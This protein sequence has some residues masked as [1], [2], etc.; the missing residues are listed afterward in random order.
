MSKAPSLRLLLGELLEVPKLL[1]SLFQPLVPLEHGQQR[2]VLV[3]PGYLANDLSTSRLRRSLKASG[4]CADGW[5]LG[6]NWGARAD[7]LDRLA[8]RLEQLSAAHQGRQV[9]L[10]GWSLGGIY[11]RE[12]AKLRPGLVD[13]VITLGTPFSGELRAN[14]AWWLY[15][16]L[17]DHGVDNPPVKIA[18]AV[19]PPMLTIAVWSPIDG[20]VA[21][22]SARGL[23]SESDQQIELLAR[24]LSL[25]RSTDAIRLI[26]ELL[27]QPAAS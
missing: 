10:I 5:G 25:A 27:V 12:V 26:G 6:Q 23:P 18:P 4:Y 2:P 16:L 24:H 15:E 7:L 3:Y 11:A 21:P 22:V 17:N 13:R 19:K 1:H 8:A 20:V 14:N 9:S